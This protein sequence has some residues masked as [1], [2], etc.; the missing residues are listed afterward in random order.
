MECPPDAQVRAGVTLT[1]LRFW[2]QQA[3]AMSRRAS[4]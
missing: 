4:A 1:C 2:L 3:E